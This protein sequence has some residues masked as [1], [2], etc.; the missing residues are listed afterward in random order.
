[1]EQDLIRRIEALE[2]EIRALKDAS[3]IP[4]ET[5]QAFRARFNLQR[6]DALPEELYE[7][8][9]L[10][11]INAPSG[12]TTV[13]TQARSAINNIITAM[14]NLGLVTPN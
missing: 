5:D 11:A 4:Y 12:G 3:S 13:D 8:T 1:M 14:E 7:N 2:M 9:P 10:S 6:F